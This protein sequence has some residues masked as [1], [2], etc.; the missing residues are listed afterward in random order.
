MKRQMK[1]NSD[2]TFGRLSPILNEHSSEAGVMKGNYFHQDLLVARKVFEN[3]PVRHIDIGSRIDGFVAHV[4]SFRAIEIFDIRPQVSSVKN[5]TFSQADLT[6][7]DDKLRECCDSISSLHAIEHFGLGRYGDPIDVN[8]HL[9]AIENIHAMLKP[10]GTFYFS[11]PIG[12]Q[13][14]EFN[15]Q[16]VFSVAYLLRI[17]SD[18]F[19]VVNFNYVDDDGD[20]SENAPLTDENIASNFNCH[21]Y[22]CGIFELKK[23]G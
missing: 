23:I 4:A 18:K 9:K 7:L 19:K 22:G 14:I 17:L 8:G 20:L 21:W 15:E 10:N 13:R 6:K 11:V 12:P 5:I 2:F 3:N 16:R 1:S